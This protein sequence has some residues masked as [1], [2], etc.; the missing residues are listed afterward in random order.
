MSGRE[1][2]VAFRSETVSSKALLQHL[3]DHDIAAKQG[4][5]YAYRLLRALQVPDLDDGV[6]RLSLSH[7]N[8]T[9]EVARCLAAL[10]EVLR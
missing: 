2:N 9:A 4:H 8:T 3:A 6:L 5:F 10:R 1:A 7:Y